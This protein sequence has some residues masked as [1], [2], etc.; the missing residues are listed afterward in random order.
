MSLAGLHKIEIKKNPDKGGS[1][2]SGSNCQILFD[3]E[4]LKGVVG[5]RFEISAGSVGRVFIEMMTDVHIE[6]EVE[7]SESKSFVKSLGEL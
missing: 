4:P 5:F 3:G 1:V 2:L 6:G 7:V